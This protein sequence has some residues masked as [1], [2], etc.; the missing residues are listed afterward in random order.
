MK[1]EENIFIL[2]LYILLYFPWQR[3]GIHL[4]IFFSQIFLELCR[5]NFERVEIIIYLGE[6]VEQKIN[7]PM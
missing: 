5:R 4:V 2:M 1:E 6:V 7:K 3:T